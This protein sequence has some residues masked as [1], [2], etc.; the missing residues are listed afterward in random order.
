MDA[1][2]HNCTRPDPSLSDTAQEPACNG[3]SRPV[4]LLASDHASYA[5]YVQQTV[6]AILSC[7]QNSSWLS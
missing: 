6:L 1:D 3:L 7:Q 5:S 2:C 4:A